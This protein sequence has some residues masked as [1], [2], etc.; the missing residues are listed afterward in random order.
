[1]GIKKCEI[2]NKD[3]EYIKDDKKYCSKDCMNAARRKRYADK[4]G[5]ERNCVMCGK[6]FS[7][8]T[9]A[10][11]LRQCCYDCV[12]NGETLTR[13]KIMDFIRKLNGNRC[14]RCGYD[15]CGAALEFHHIDPNQKDFTIS[16]ER[17]KLIEAI[18]ESKKCV[19]LCANCHREIHA[20]LFDIT[21]VVK[22]GK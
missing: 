18:E 12:P 16:N 17:L 2:C 6:P 19:L 22:N 14:M 20:N 7:P 5:M 3:M 8:L 4:K 1:M 10:A 21:E 9:S 15:T 13:G 11:N